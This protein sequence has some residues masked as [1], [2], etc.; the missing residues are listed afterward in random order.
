MLTNVRDEEFPLNV[1]HSSL[2]DIAV[3]LDHHYFC[4]GLVPKILTGAQNAG[5]GFQRL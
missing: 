3:R 1:S 5:N 4:A 2:G